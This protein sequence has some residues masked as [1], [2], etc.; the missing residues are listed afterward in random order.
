MDYKA[1]Y[2]FIKG[3]FQAFIETQEATCPSSPHLL[4]NSIREELNITLRQ[5]NAMHLSFSK[6]FD[7]SIHIKFDLSYTPYQVAL[8]HVQPS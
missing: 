6:A 8:V 4:G 7:R 1:N 3:N 2:E 5:Y